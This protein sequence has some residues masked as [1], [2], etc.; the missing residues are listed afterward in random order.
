MVAKILK[1]IP[2]LGVIDVSR[3]Y[4]VLGKHRLVKLFK[5][6]WNESKIFPDTIN[7][8]DRKDKIK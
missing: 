7:I 8:R 6:L 2:H 4:K 3:Y 5:N 1:L